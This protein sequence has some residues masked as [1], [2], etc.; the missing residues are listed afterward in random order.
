V[1]QTI[2]PPPAGDAP[3]D[4]PPRTWVRWVIAAACLP[5]LA[6]WIYAFGFASKKATVHLDDKAWTQRA[7]SICEAANEQR[8]QLFD[9]RKITDVGSDA[10]V[11]RAT[12]VD[13][14][15]DIIE[16]MLNE[17]VAIQPDSSAD[18][19]LVAQWE[20]YYRTLIQDRRTYTQ[21]LRDGKANQFNETVVDDEPLSSYLDDFAKPN[22]MPECVSPNDLS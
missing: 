6:M 7:E 1:T 3:A 5:I 14:A 17:I 11:Q 13:Q 4:R 12:I 20:G 15:T 8:D 18:R 21:G 9:A 2:A 22:Y 10:L 19:A 16:Q